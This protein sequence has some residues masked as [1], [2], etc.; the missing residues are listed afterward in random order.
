M[1][2]VVRPASPQQIGDREPDGRSHADTEEQQPAR[3]A[4]GHIDPPCR[5]PEGE[6]DQRDERV[7]AGRDRGA[8]HEPGD[9]GRTRAVFVIDEHPRD[10][11]EPGAEEEL[12]RHLRVRVAA[13]ERLRQRHR[14]RDRRSG[15]RPRSE[16]AEAE[17][18]EGEERHTA[19]EGRH[20]L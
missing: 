6:D 12:H 5:H 15:G 19:S 16:P 1:Q 18:E 7:D 17:H 11:C 4:P 13:E 20:D 10:Q 3:S 8:E 9:E 2:V 14:D